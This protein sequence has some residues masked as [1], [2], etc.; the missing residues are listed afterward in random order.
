MLT[1]TMFRHHG[2]S[3]RLVVIAA[4][5]RHCVDLEQ[6][7]LVGLV[8][9]QIALMKWFVSLTCALLMQ[10]ARH[11]AYFG[12]ASTLCCHER[13]EKVKCNV[14]LTCILSGYA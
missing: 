6:M 12:L 1:L 14:T 3:V 13:S 7:L 5:S 11:D 8:E 10:K 4:K 9:S 2:M